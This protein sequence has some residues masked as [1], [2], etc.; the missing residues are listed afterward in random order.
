LAGS[1]FV[2]RR[3]ARIPQSAIT[4]YDALMA[5]I[6]TFIGVQP[7]ERVIRN[8][9]SIVDRMAVCQAGYNW[10]AKENLNVTLNY[11]GDVVDVEVPELCKLIKQ[12]VQDF[13][14]F[15]MSLQSVNGFPNME[16]P[17]TIW[18]GVDE[19]ADVFRAL[20]KSVEDVL[21][22]WGVN[23]DRNEYLP[24]MTLGKL[25]RGGR[26]NDALLEKAD[27]LRRHDGGFCNI[28]KV[29]VFS[30]YLDRSGPT[31]TPMATIPLLG[32]KE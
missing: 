28:E 12:A 25:K 30:S 3:F 23:K 7:S 11:A 26:W 17:R 15:E 1:V 16:Q 14:P 5:S 22:H 21:S 2:E 13:P 10:V 20:N 4:I 32:S 24:H 27:K 18:I 6:R 31:N 8:V 29:I 9:A 19:G